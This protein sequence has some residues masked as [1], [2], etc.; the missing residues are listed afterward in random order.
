MY[1]VE[2]ATDGL[3]A[4]EKLD[5]QWGRYETVLLD[6]NM[7]QMDG[8]QLIQIL[9]QQTEAWLQS[10]VVLS[11]DHDALCQAVRMGI[12]HVLAKPFD[13][14]TVLA[15]VSSCHSLNVCGD[16]SKEDSLSITVEW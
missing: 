15:Q 13:L 1:E 12:C 14:E 16:A 7:P 9:R 2:T 5:R 3:M 8:L 6:V 10:I 11:T 4:L